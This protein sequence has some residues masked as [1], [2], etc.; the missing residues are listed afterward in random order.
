M[1]DFESQISHLI[2]F[3]FWFLRVL[4][5][6]F[7]FSSFSYSFL[8]LFFLAFHPYLVWLFAFCFFC[9]FASTRRSR[10]GKRCTV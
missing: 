7:H 5:S 2:I 4:L 8:V 10:V 9:L 6:L 1:P 3:S